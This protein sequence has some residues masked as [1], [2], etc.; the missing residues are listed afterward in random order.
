MSDWDDV[1]T[2][3]DAIFCGE[4]NGPI[5]KRDKNINQV[6]LC[7]TSNS[8]SRQPII[9]S[10]PPH[11]SAVLWTIWVQVEIVCLIYHGCRHEYDSHMN[12]SQRKCTIKIHHI[13]ITVF[14]KVI[15]HHEPCITF[16]SWWHR[17]RHLLFSMWP[18]TERWC[19]RSLRLF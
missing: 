17:R 18:H 7:K 16:H 11:K 8:L 2:S 19:M 6:E 1:K 10:M 12:L 15:Y 9:I 14:Y 5:I 3:D 4:V 13:Y